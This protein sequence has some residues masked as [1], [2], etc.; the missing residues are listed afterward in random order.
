[1]RAALATLQSMSCSGRRV[2]VLGKMAELGD[3]SETEHYRLGQDAQRTYGIDALFVV[4][5]SAT[6]IRKGYVD[7][8][9]SIAYQFDS[10]ESCRDAL[11]DLLGPNDMILV[12]G[13]RSAGMEKVI[14]ETVAP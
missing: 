7:A 13:S 11:V 3:R 9:G 4:G 5:G 1:M 2:A 8:G 14:P 6:A 10:H 12:K